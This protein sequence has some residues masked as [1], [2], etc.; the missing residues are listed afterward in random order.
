M[1]YECK[2]N[3]QYAVNNLVDLSVTSENL[4]WKLAAYNQKE[5]HMIL[6]DKKKRKISSILIVVLITMGIIIALAPIIINLIFSYGNIGTSKFLGDGDWLAFWGNYSG[7]V[8]GG[9]CTIITILFTII[10]YEK[11]EDEHRLEMEEQE[12]KHREELVQREERQ[13]RPLLIV[14][15]NGG[16]GTSGNYSKVSV[17]IKNVGIYAAARVRVADKY[18]DILE[19]NEEK[20][21]EIKSEDGKYCSSL[22]IEVESIIGKHYDWIFDLMK[23]EHIVKD[24]GSETEKYYYKLREEEYVC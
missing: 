3:H 12:K 8:I 10:F 1:L 11:Q 17:H 2:F 6:M 5:R 13:Y 18:I 20:V 24:N 21:V 22:N 19:V 23:V 15:P 4:E 16:S 9:I 14:I 7:G